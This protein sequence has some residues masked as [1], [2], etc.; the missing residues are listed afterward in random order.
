MIYIASDMCE[1]PLHQADLHDV[2]SHHTARYLFSMMRRLFQKSPEAKVLFG[3]P[4]DMDTNSPEMLASK[5]FIIQG[6]YLIKM[7]DTALNMLGPD[8]E[9]LTDI[10]QDLGAKHVRYGVKPEMFGIMGDA[11]IKTLQET[12]GGGLMTESC[13]EAWK[14]TYDELSRDMIKAMKEKK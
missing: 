4:I 10:L 12:L 14:K 6:S 8:I 3:F 2:C 13:I 1:S 5:R 9:L 7:L 11:L